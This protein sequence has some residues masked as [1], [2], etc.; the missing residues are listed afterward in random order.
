MGFIFVGVVLA[1]I[2]IVLF[3][4]ACAIINNSNSPEEDEEQIKYLREYKRG[5]K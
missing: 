5:C 3:F 4:K 2:V 1:D